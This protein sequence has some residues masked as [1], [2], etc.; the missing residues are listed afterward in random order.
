MLQRKPD[1]QMEQRRRPIPIKQQHVIHCL[2]KN[3]SATF[4]ADRPTDNHKINIYDIRFIFQLS[5]VQEGTYSCLRVKISRGAVVNGVS[6]QSHEE[7]FRSD[8]F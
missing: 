4:N 1:V 3:T 7:S 5:S 6:A 2:Y 8:T